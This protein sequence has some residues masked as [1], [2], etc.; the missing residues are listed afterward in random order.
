MLSPDDSLKQQ[1][2]KHCISQQIKR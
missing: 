1:K 2:W